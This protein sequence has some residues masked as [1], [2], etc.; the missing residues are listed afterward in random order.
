MEGHAA[1][2]LRGSGRL[3]PAV[4]HGRRHR[5][6]YG[7]LIPRLPRG[8]AT[9]ARGAALFLRETISRTRYAGAEGPFIV[10]AYRPF[11]THSIVA[12]CRDK[13]VRFSITIRQHQ[14]RRNIT[15]VTPG[16]GL[17]PIHYWMDGAADLAETAYIPFRHEPDAERC[18]L[19]SGGSKPS[20][21]LNRRW[22]ATTAIMPSSPTG[23]AAPWIAKPTIDAT[24]RR[25]TPSTSPHQ[26]HRRL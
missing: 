22:L 6:A 11:Y 18:G 17:M 24:P 8:R 20:P 2:Q 4:V 10:R 23:T 21:A 3:S 14:S 12:A 16:A 5:S 9:T 15:E 19:P 7:G 1:P 13:S 25:K 26:V